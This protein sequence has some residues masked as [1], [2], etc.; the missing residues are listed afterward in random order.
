[1]GGNT[2]IKAILKDPFV[3]VVGM[4]A[5]TLCTAMNQAKKYSNAWNSVHLAN[6]VATPAADPISVEGVAKDENFCPSRAFFSYI[7]SPSYTVTI[8][9]AYGEKHIHVEGSLIRRS[10]QTCTM[11]NDHIDQGD[12]VRVNGIDQTDLGKSHYIVDL[13]S[14]EIL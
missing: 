13:D 3:Y 5:L 14:L 8:E 7:S 10:R 12:T 2:G 11:L 4:A 1:M 9:T 6:Y